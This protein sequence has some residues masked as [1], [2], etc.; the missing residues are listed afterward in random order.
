MTRILREAGQVLLLAALM[1]SAV[2]AII[3]PTAPTEAGVVILLLI[4]LW[5]RGPVIPEEALWRARMRHRFFILEHCPWLDKIDEDEHGALY[6]SR[7][8]WPWW[9]EP[10]ALVEVCNH[11]PE[12]D[13]T[14]RSF[15]LRVPPSMASAKEAVA[16]TFGME[17]DVYRPEDES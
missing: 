16:W 15:V 1:L 5:M 4:V 13:G 12:L 6:R 10:V 7:K 9:E 14:F 17:H 11:T 3:L 8:L 2:A